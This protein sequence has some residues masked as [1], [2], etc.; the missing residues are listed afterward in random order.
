M[1]KVLVVDDHPANRELIVVLLGYAGHQTIEAA[2]GH[3]ALAQVRAERPDLVVCG[4][5]PRPVSA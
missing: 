2:D 3:L 4:I 5:S 1:A